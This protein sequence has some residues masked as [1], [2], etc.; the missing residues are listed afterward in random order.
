MVRPAITEW[1]A[2]MHLPS[3]TCA[4]WPRLDFRELNILRSIRL[5]YLCPSASEP[6]KLEDWT[7]KARA[8]GLPPLLEYGAGKL[9]SSHGQENARVSCAG[10]KVRGRRHPGPRR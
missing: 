9:S 4:N 3:K 6:A 2:G 8:C 10:R 7:E 1:H 5:L